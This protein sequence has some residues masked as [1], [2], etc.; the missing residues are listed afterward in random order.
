[1]QYV[2]PGVVNK[3]LSWNAFVPLSRLSYAVYLVHFFIQDVETLS[4][5]TTVSIR[6]LSPV[7]VVVEIFSKLLIIL[8]ES[9]TC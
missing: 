8:G 3:I 4:T 1:M 9:P 6:L 7:S 2:C 5:R